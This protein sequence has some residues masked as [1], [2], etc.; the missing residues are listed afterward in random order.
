MA[1]D[2]V[3]EDPIGKSVTNPDGSGISVRRSA[4]SSTQY[5]AANR[6]DGHL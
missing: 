2:V 1:D 5:I 3:I 6:L 4:P